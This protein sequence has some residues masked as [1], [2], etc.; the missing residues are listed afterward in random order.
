MIEPASCDADIP[1]VKLAGREWPVPELAVRQLRIVRRPLID[2]TDAIAATETETMGQ[3]VMRLTTAQYEEL[4]EIVYQ[5]LTR[6]HPSL[7]REEFLD[8]QAS[9]MELFMAF[10]VV[11]RQSGI[12][13]A[14][15]EAPPTG[16]A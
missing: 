5:G 11:R 15:G 12:F 13:V 6:A 4:C 14:A 3:R 2:L 8:M 10:L 9:D 1:R 7:T 16:E